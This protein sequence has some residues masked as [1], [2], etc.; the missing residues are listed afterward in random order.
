MN[1][2]WISCFASPAANFITLD[3]IEQHVQSLE[4]T[5]ALKDKRLIR[6]RA[7]E[8]LVRLIKEM[9]QVA[10]DTSTPVISIQSEIEED[11]V[12]ED[13]FARIRS[14]SVEPLMTESWEVSR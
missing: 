12:P 6:E 4:V 1:N 11:R 10:E 2:R 9:D 14:A 7:D 5:E 3:P 13:I 8:D